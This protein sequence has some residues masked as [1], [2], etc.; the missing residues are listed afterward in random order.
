LAIQSRDHLKG[1]P[2]QVYHDDDDDDEVP[3]KIAPCMSFAPTFVMTGNPEV[4]ATFW[5][6]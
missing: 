2:Y 4:V 3:T 5:L 1:A 6:L